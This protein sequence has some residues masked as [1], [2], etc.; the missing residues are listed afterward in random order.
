[1]KNSKEPATF[2]LA[3]QCLNQ[4][5]PACTREKSGILSI[6][7]EVWARRVTPYP[8]PFERRVTVSG[9]LAFSIC[10]GCV[11]WYPMRSISAA[12]LWTDDLIS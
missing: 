1:M 9:T 11:E 5:R 6:R 8:I 3:A 4:L 2:R 12:C 10:F 7:F